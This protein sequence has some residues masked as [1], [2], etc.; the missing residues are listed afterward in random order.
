RQAFS[1]SRV[2]PQDIIDDY[3]HRIQQFPQTDFYTQRDYKYWS[4]ELEHL[5]KYA[6]HTSFKEKAQELGR[7]IVNIRSL[8][9][10]KEWNHVRHG[11]ICQGKGHI[12]SYRPDL[13]ELGYTPLKHIDGG[14]FFEWD[15]NAAL[16]NALDL[17]KVLGEFFKKLQT[18]TEEDKKAAAATAN[19]TSSSLSSYTKSNKNKAKPH[20]TTP[21]ERKQ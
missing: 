11:F 5:K 4:K 1:L 10:V 12:D 14:H 17:E 8:H 3:A 18:Q 2:T 13:R 16:A 9:H 15:P 7:H 6:A 21:Y 19:S 20:T